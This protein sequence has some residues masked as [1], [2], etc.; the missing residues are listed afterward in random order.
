MNKELKELCKDLKHGLFADRGTDLKE[1]TEFM[2]RT[3]KAACPKPGDFLLAKTGIQIFLNTL[4]NK[5][6]ELNK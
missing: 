4:V 5:L 2:D 6:E 3:L 1:A